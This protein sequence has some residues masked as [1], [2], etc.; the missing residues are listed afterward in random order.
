MWVGSA[1]G[2]GQRADHDVEVATREFWGS[3]GLPVRS[4]LANE[5]LE[6]L[7][8]EFF[9]S[10]LASPEA[11]GSFNFHFFAE[12]IDGVVDLHIE[13][14]GIDGGRELDFLYAIGVLVFLGFLFAFR[15]FVAIFSVIDEPADRRDCVGCD[16]D[17]VHLVRPGHIDGIAQR[18]DAELLAVHA[19]DADFAGT[20]FPVDPDERA[21][22][23]RTEVGALQDTP[24][25]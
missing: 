1:F 12:E 20:D 6:C 25:G 21:G 18:N 11:Q 13:V 19:D 2:A 22:W 5:L 15:E 7:K 23:W 9:V 10:H 3:V 24:I 8:A 16:F 17:Q 4:Q 14:M